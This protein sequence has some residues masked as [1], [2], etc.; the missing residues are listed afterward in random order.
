MASASISQRKHMKKKLIAHSQK[1]NAKRLPWSKPTGKSKVPGKGSRK[2]PRLDP[3]PPGLFGSS[4][5]SKSGKKSSGQKESP[6]SKPS[7]GKLPL[8]SSRIQN[9]PGIERRPEMKDM[10]VGMDLHSNN[11]MIGWMDAEGKRLKHQRLPNSLN[12]ILACLKPQYN[13][14]VQIGVEATYNWYWLVDG[15]V[16]AQYPVVLAHPAAM[17]QYSGLKHADD[18][19]DSYFIADL[20]RLKILPT[21]HIYDPK[22]RPYRDLLRRRQLLVHQRTSQLLSLK[23]LYARTTGQTLGQGAA[24]ALDPKDL[25]RLFPHPA[26]H[27]IASQQVALI[28]QLTSGIGALE[29]EVEAVADKLPCY[30]QLQTLPGIGRILALTISMETGPIERFIESGNYAS[31]CRCVQADRESNGKYKGDNNGKC[32][33]K[34]LAWAYV[35]GA[36]FARRYD[37]ASRRFFER[38]QAKT[39]TTVA[40]KALACKLSKAG[41]HVMT[42]NVAYDPQRVFPFLRIPVSTKPAKAA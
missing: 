1:G 33:N 12:E 5:S 8:E 41:W 16:K 35:E 17:K 22:L 39:N 30:H 24:K 27:W 4:S 19:S 38:K 20:Q 11:V 9:E 14:I 23:S 29:K 2:E 7:F 28:E 21:G 18:A 31:Y 36:H 26:D 32:G 6:S 42:K 34:Y 37:A 15:L 10:Y 3:I 25:K 40:T 13:H